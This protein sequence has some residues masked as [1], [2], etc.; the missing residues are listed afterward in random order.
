MEKFRR[1]NWTY[2]SGGAAALAE[3]EE[4][5]AQ[6]GRSR[7][8]ITYSELVRDVA[9]DLPNLRESPRTINVADWQ[10]LDRAIV[11]S[12]LGFISMRSYLEARFWASALV[13]SR[14][15]GSPGEGFYTLL[16]DIGLIPTTQSEKA[17]DLWA[18]HVAKAHTWYA[19][20]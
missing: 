6:A 20:N 14:M 8:L 7:A 18:D 1:I 2:A 10:D 13:V 12:F 19:K 17:F 3:L 4:R 16:K 9:F 5:I 11:G 15:D